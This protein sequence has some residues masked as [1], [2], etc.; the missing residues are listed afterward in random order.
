MNAYLH[1]GGAF[2]QEP[3]GP[4]YTQDTFAK[5]DELPWQKRGLQY[6]AS[7]YGGRIPTIYKVLHNR[8]WKRVYCACYGNSGT[9][10]IEQGRK[11]V[12]KV[13]IY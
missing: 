3:D 5:V 6:T 2:T 4:F 8:R 7:G 13:D 10:Y 11:P 1:F 9:C 12:A